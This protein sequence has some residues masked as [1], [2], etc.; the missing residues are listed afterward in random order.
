[1]Q[2]QSL[3]WKVSIWIAWYSLNGE[4]SSVD[5]PI[6]LMNPILFHSKTTFRGPT[7]S[8]SFSFSIWFLYYVSTIVLIIGMAPHEGRHY[9]FF[10][11]QW[12]LFPCNW[13]SKQ[14]AIGSRMVKELQVKRLHWTPLNIPS[15]A[16]ISSPTLNTRVDNMLIGAIFRKL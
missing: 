10:H 14:E 12:S 11:T 16:S 9:S 6:L 2:R 8:S 5:Y 3:E 4:Y 1:M 13:G 15:I 7:N